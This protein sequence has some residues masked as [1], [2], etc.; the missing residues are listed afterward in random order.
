MIIQVIFRTLFIFSFILFLGCSKEVL[1]DPTVDEVP[2][3]EY[4][5]CSLECLEEIVPSAFMDSPN[6]F[7][8]SES[9][10]SIQFTGDIGVNAWASQCGNSTI[11]GHFVNYTTSSHYL[12]TLEVHATVFR[13]PQDCQQQ[14]SVARFIYNRSSQDMHLNLKPSNVFGSSPVQFE[15]IDSNDSVDVKRIYHDSLMLN[16]RMFYHVHETISSSRTSYKGFY[17]TP[18]QGIVAFYNRTGVLYTLQ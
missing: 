17:V 15:F 6:L 16:Q 4:R 18:T 11:S 3:I 7:Y 8:T 14:T 2:A 10:D 1:D 9:G 5:S 12:L 13:D